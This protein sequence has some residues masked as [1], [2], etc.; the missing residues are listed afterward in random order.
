VRLNDALS[1]DHNQAGD[2][3]SATLDHPLIVDGLVIA[4]RGSR[5]EGK[6][7]S[8]EKAGRVKG[9]SE[10]SI[11]LVRLTTSDGQRVDLHTE[12]WAKSGPTS[13]KEDAAKV[14]GGAALGAIIGA[15]AGGGR[16]AAIGAGVGGA[17]GAGGTMATR[18]KAV[19]LPVETRISF[20]LHEPV[21]I[22]EK[23]R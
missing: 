23:L 1:T 3:F 6:V 17:A 19:V 15:I 13:K 5:L 20:R 11:E 4:E 21:T 18:G 2:A 10:L 8:S 14:G 12:P 22:T 7:V 16:G 9:V